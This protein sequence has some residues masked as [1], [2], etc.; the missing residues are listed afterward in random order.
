MSRMNNP[1]GGATVGGAE[2]Q[3]LNPFSDAGAMHEEVAVSSASAG[4]STQASTGRAAA[5]SVKSPEMTELA[6]MTDLNV[7]FMMF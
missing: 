7:L 3:R 1:V 4:G 6:P 5:V 2:F